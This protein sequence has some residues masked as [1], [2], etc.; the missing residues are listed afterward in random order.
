MFVQSFWILI[1]CFAISTFTYAAFSTILLS[2]PADLFPS[3]SV[4]TVSGMGGTAA[5]IGTI[6]ATLLTGY[7]SD[8]Y[9]FQPILLGA[10]TVSLLAMV[11]VLTLVR[12]NPATDAGLV[13]RI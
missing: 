4:A 10:G 8:R 9:S 6:A 2:L 13:R 1:A 3:H 5:G 11:A 12:N 7:I